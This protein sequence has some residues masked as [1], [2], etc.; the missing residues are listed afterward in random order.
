MNH[1]QYMYK[2]QCLTDIWYDLKTRSVKI[3]QNVIRRL[4]TPFQWGNP[5]FEE[6][7]TFVSSR[8]LPATRYN[9]K[10]CLA[11]LGLQEYNIWEIIAKT[12]G[13]MMHSWCWFRFDT[14]PEGYN[15]VEEVY[16][17]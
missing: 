11:I 4:E 7:E 6:L 2:D 15:A 12:H 8:C 10:E 1:M 9:I 14:D 17:W 16:P 5:T 13:V 3:Q